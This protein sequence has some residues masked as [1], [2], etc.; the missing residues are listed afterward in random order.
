MAD[1]RREPTD[2]EARVLRWLEKK[3]MDFIFQYEI[4]G[5]T[6]VRGGILVDVVAFVPWAQPIEIF[7]E[8]WHESEITGEERLRLARIE[9]VFKREVIV[10]WGKDLESDEETDR[11]MSEKIGAPL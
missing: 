8:H 7:G 10:L 5:G 3:K 1:Y 6:A 11:I 9:E 2:I 4:A